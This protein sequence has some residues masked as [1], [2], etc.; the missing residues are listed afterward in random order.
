[1]Q[2]FSGVR[3]L[4]AAPL[5]RCWQ[6]L[7][8]VL[9]AQERG[10]A[11]LVPRWQARPQTCLQACKAPCRD[12][13]LAVPRQCLMRTTCASLAAGASENSRRRHQVAV[14]RVA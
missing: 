5:L 11:E 2:R 1:M 13:R 7:T 3:L 12:C 8:G 4:A 9:V 10:A 14:V 6:A